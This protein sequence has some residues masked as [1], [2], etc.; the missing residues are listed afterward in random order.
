MNDDPREPPPRPAKRLKRW[1]RYALVR[2]AL[3]VVS[4][5]PARFASGL[6]DR[7]GALAFHVARGERRKALASL[8]RAFPALGQEAR[9]ALALSMFRHLGRCAFEL[10]CVSQL[11][12]RID[13]WVEWPEADRKVLETALA[14]GKGVVFV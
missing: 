10:A 1:A 14:R 11:D 9:A 7:F 5:L 2:V 6:G 13:S 4:V 3:A 8:E 12:A